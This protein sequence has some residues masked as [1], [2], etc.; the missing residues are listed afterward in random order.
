MKT[1]QKPRFTRVS[2]RELIKSIKRNG[3]AD[4]VGGKDNNGDWWAYSW[5]VE[6][7]RETHK[8]GNGVAAP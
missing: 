7:Y 5:S 4:V 6:R 8:P 3:V 1:R 2:D